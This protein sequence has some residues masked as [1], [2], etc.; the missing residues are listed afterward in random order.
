VRRLTW[1]SEYSHEEAERLIKYALGVIQREAPGDADRVERR[2]AFESALLG[3]E[4]RHLVG[5]SDEKPQL[6]LEPVIR[7][8]RARLPDRV[9]WVVDDLQKALKD[10]RH[11][12]VVEQRASIATA[13]GFPWTRANRRKLKGLEG[14]AQQ[15]LA[16]G[17]SNTLELPQRA[18][19]AHLIESL[20]EPPHVGQFLEIRVTE[21][22]H[23]EDDG[24]AV[25]SVE[26]KG[27]QWPTDE[28]EKAQRLARAVDGREWKHRVVVPGTVPLYYI[29]NRPTGSGRRPASYGAREVLMAL[30]TREL[31]L[32][33]T[34]QACPAVSVLLDLYFGQEADAPTIERWWY[35]LPPTAAIHR[36]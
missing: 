16:F 5:K 32:T 30:A 28:C 36:T 2:K 20:Q 12:K 4:F 35:R 11:E 14:V 31:G 18:P 10:R 1:Q 7:V 24:H 23:L 13:S 6:E 29:L 34:G 19:I 22:L 26:S 25:Q 8:A 15:F 27:E 21:D 3:P 9:I 33:A 17:T